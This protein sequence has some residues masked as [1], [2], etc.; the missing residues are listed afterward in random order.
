MEDEDDLTQTSIDEL[1][2]SWETFLVAVNGREE[3][4]NFK[5]LWHDCIQE[6]GHIQ[7]NMVNSKEENLSLTTRTEK[8]RNPFASKN[9]FHAKKK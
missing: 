6:E 7:N 8:E 3:H 9:T 2:S 1:P 5:I 4:P